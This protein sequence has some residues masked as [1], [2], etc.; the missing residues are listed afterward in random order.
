[1]LLDRPHDIRHRGCGDGN[2][3]RAVGRR[4]LRRSSSCSNTGTAGPKLSSPKPCPPGLRPVR[5]RSDGGGRPNIRRRQAPPAPASRGT[6]SKCCRGY[7][8]MMQLPSIAN[9]A[10]SSLGR[11]PARLARDTRNA[12]RD[13]GNRNVGTELFRRTIARTAC[14]DHILEGSAVSIGQ[15]PRF[16]VDRTACHDPARPSGLRFERDL[17]QA[18]LPLPAL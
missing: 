15:H 3:A 13:D 16:L 8:N 7:P 18:I 6:R 1:M 5:R 17:R 12:S 11:S 2:R 14:A 4:F 9:R 10:F